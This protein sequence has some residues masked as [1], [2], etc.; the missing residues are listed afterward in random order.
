MNPSY[1]HC[2]FKLYGCL[3]LYVFWCCGKQMTKQVHINKLYKNILE[4][5]N[6]QNNYV[7]LLSLGF[8]LTQKC[9]DILLYI[10]SIN[11]NNNSHRTESKTTPITLWIMHLYSAFCVLLYTQSALQS[12]FTIIYPIKACFCSAHSNVWAFFHN[13]RG[14]R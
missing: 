1:I 6:I 7:M 13:S 2:T 3:N 11:N 9:T 5:S 8:A 4:I 12:C 14:L 10:I